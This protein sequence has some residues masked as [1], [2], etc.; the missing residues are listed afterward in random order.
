[1]KSSSRDKNSR[2][3][4]MLLLAVV[5][6][7]FLPSL[8]ALGTVMVTQGTLGLQVIAGATND[9]WA[10]P[11]PANSVFD[12]WVGDS[13]LLANPY[14][15]HTML[16]M[17][18]NEASLTA[19][20]KPSNAWFPATNLLNGLDPGDQNAVNLI[21]Y[22]P[23]NPS[24]VI[25]F[26]NGAR[27]SA[28]DFF[29]ET[30]SSTFARDAA[31]AGYGVAALDTA[32]R[33]GK[34][35]DTR[36][37]TSNADIV[38][39]QAA[40]DYFI[41]QGLMRSNTARFATG[42]SAGGFFAPL[43]A[44]F[45]QFNACAL[46]CSSGAPRSASPTVFNLT[47][48]PTLW[49]LAQN[50]DRYNHKAFL[51]DSSNNLALLAGRGVAGELREHAPSPVYPGR[52]RRIEGL[53]AA[54]SQT[55]YDQLKEAALLDPWDFLVSSPFNNGNHWLGVVSG[56]SAY[57]NAIQNQLNTCYSEH[58]FF[59]DF[60][61]DTLRFFGEHRPPVPSRGRILARA[62]KGGIGL[63]IPADPGQTYR[64]QASDDLQ[65]WTAVL[66][67][68]SAGGTFDFSD[69]DSPLRAR[70]FYRTISP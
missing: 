55:I 59:S 6:P 42:M 16:V 50:D 58:H 61:N 31:V 15:W 35:W 4:A 65:S 17:P 18:S 37:T 38:N 24:G 1:M 64:L 44:Y 53:T 20:F 66:T 41:G 7:L 32:D 45:L 14:A 46:W 21:Y 33:L 10:E 56:Y 57:T 47:A 30:E 40:L 67:N 39:V 22:F 28:S 70:G 11:P 51:A 36:M 12:R 3:L 49:N 69:I 29:T 19:T 5:L 9:I 68:G 52:F 8:R 27:G 25:F 13:P 23:A 2:Y 62:T 34:S 43:P 54:D 60:G 63:M 48:V 26:F